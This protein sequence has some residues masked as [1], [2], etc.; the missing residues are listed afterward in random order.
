MAAPVEIVDRQKFAEMLQKT[1]PEV[2][3]LASELPTWPV[4]HS[5][6]KQL[7][8]MK[9]VTEEPRDPTDE[10]KERINVGVLAMRNFE[11]SHPALA[12]RLQ[13]LDYAF[14]RYEALP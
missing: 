3:K 5:A 13:E 2:Q 10:E 6:L 14:R 7:E 1:L 8:F 11:E 9:T 4:I 12:D